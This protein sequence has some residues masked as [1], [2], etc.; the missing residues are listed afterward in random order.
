MS[1]QETKVFGIDL[2]TTYS[3]IAYVDEYGKAV[4]VPNVEGD[5][6]TPSVVYFEGSSRVVGK[7]AKNS[8]VLYS[9]QVVEMVKRQMGEAD[10]LFEYEGTKYRA[11]EIS[12]YI[13]RKLADDAELHLGHP[14]K[15]VVITCPAYFGIAQREATAR[16]GEIAGLNVREVI[17]EPTAAAIMYGLQNERD[18]VV[19]V[20]DLGGGTFNITV[21][22]IKGGAITVVAT[23]GDHHLGGRNWDEAIVQ[24]LAEQWMNDTGSTDDPLESMET[25]QDLWGKAESAKRALSAKMETTVP[26]MHAGQRVGVTLS[27]DKFNELTANLLTRTID[28]THSTIQEAEKWDFTHSTIQEAEKWDFNNFD[29]IL[30]VGGSTKMPQVVERLKKEF[31]IPLRSFDPDEAVA[32]G[33]ACYGQKL[34]IGEIIH[35]KPPVA[36]TNLKPPVAH[37]N[38]NFFIL[39]GLD[40][41]APWNQGAFEHL[42]D[43]KQSEWSI[44]SGG[45]GARAITAQKNRELIPEIKRVMSDPA[46]RNALAAAA[47]K[48]RTASNKDRIEIFERQLAIAQAKGYLEQ[49]ELAKLIADFK[50]VLSEREIRSRIKVPERAPSPPGGKSGQ[51]LEPSL[52]K[53]IS[54]QLKTLGMEDLYQLLA[55]PRTTSCQEL[56][57]AAQQLGRDMLVR[58]PKTSE[59]TAKGNLAGLA[60]DIFQS[61]EKRRK[62]D[63]SLLESSLNVLLKQLDE[64]LSRTG[65]DQ[66]K[67]LYAGQV[68]IFLE[69]AAK[70][71]WNNEHAFTKLREHAMKRKWFLETP[72]IEIHANT[73]RC[74]HCQAI[75]DKA[76]NFCFSCNRPLSSLCPDCGQRVPSDEAVCGNCGFPTGNAE[77]VDGLLTECKLYLAQSD[78]PMAELRLKMAEGAWAPKK[79]D[80]RHQKILAFKAEIQ[81]LLQAQQKN[82]EQLRQL[83]DK[84]QYYAARQF[85]TTIP[86]DMLSAQPSL[87]QT[88]NS[89]ISRAQELVR[90]AQSPT[91]SHE[92]KFD[93]CLQALH[94]CADYKD[95]GY[96]LSTTPPAPPRNLQARIG[97]S[98]VSLTWELSPNRGVS[99]KIVRKSRSQPVSVKD[100]VLLETVTG[101]MYDDFKPEIGVPIFYAVFAA[102]ED[103]CSTQAATLARPILMTQDVSNV[104]AKVDDRLVD[105]SWQLPVNVQ[106]VIVVRK[107]KTP[108]R[109]IDDGKQLP[110]VDM[111]HLV[112]R[113]VLNDIMYFYGIYCQFKDY[114]NQLVASVGVIKNAAPEVPP[115]PIMHLDITSTRVSQGHEVKLR[116]QAPLKGRALILK[117][118]QR[119]P[120]RPGET[121]PRA[122]VDKQG[123]LLEERPDTLTDTWSQPGIAYYT[124]IVLFQEMAYIGTSLQHVCVDD[125]NDLKYQNLGSTLRLQWTWPANCQEVLVAFDTEGWPNPQGARTNTQKVTRAEYDSSGYYDIRRATNQDYYIVIAA[126][127]KQGTEQIVAPGVRMQ[128]LYPFDDKALEADR[129]KTVIFGSVQGLVQ[130]EYNTVTFNFQ[131]SKEERTVPFL[132]PPRP[133]QDLVGR[134]DLLRNL[135]RKL[136][137]GGNLALSALNG[138]PGVGKTALALAL[139]HDDKLLGHFCDGVLWAGLGRESNVFSHLGTWG[140]TLGI[141]QPEMEKMTS[142]HERTQAIHR[143]IGTRR[144]LLVIDDA[145]SVEAA[146]AFRL[147]GPNC[148]HLV[149]TRLPEVA[150]AFAGEETISVRELGEAEGL[151]L[152]ERL[153]PGVIEASLD[154]VQELV[155]AVGG[156]P[157][158]LTLMG[159]YLR[160]Q[161]RNRQPRRL[162]AALDRLHQMKERLRLGQPQAGLERHPSLSEGVPL[163]QLEVI[164]ISDEAL[165][166]EARQALRAFSVFP[167]KPN[168]FSEEA[169]LA[170]A[171]TSIKTID[172][173]TDFGLVESIGF[174]RYTLHQTISDYAKIE[175]TDNTA[176]ERMVEFFIDYVEVHKSDNRLLERETSNILAAVEIMFEQEM[177]PAF[178]RGASAFAHFIRILRKTRAF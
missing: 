48:E 45:V 68:K 92:Q 100:G 178:G 175:L 4:V 174:G 173:L 6:T 18:Q 109:A 7:E 115:A 168:A 162:R 8:A 13:L 59:V 114:N 105:L 127:F 103:I 22:E 82:I 1:D 141:S 62:Y 42:I 121:V 87:V 124:P 54:Q 106:N 69:E 63:E 24:Y 15:D 10:W 25:L 30:L 61:E 67:G 16:A 74:G 88:I 84:R 43:A 120:F 50:D 34:V 146:L 165:D 137:A 32:K 177:Q 136:F 122:L 39:L 81:R 143:M 97:G 23:G 41:D 58:L 27:R 145:W 110:L 35:F 52:L 101:R 125:V 112:D 144:M 55:L 108:P 159:N 56:T 149:T 131:G 135:K 116:W 102:Y 80:E 142:V 170:V 129:N 169:A 140:M 95:A 79:S 66:Q 151:N 167:S 46:L 157:L 160:V 163:S 96:I 28:F 128:Y 172:T 176:Y 20:Y 123:I 148:A 76:R 31:S 19:L 14:V 38:L 139:A 98:T 118:P 78:L 44:Q 49:A 155:H 70:V 83:I 73:Q 77:L 93:F 154:E 147:G 171:A 26:V 36:H 72:L 132:A 75:N 99:Y 104:I 40:P 64:S 91:V 9:E 51:S 89:E 3:C 153:A 138:L 94:I 33:A 156:L 71:G 65:S 107:E 17:N 119:V 134:D 113:N 47:K 2:G 126:L 5:R 37:T 164:K 161:M 133:H 57:R 158:P 12:S 130:G 117:S 90:R 21:I 85:I 86:A 29:Q 60:K 53:D 11:E 166:E 111:Q 150:D 152:L